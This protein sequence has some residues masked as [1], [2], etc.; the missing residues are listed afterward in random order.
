VRELLSGLLI[1]AM[2]FVGGIMGGT[3]IGHWLLPHKS[4]PPQVVTVPDPQDRACHLAVHAHYEAWRD[5]MLGRGDVLRVED[6]A[7]RLVEACLHEYAEE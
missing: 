6:A 5:W 7:D 1:A 3:A 2:G 4:P